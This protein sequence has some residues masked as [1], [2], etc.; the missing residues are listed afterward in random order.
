MNTRQ[1]TIGA[2]LVA[3]AL[4]AFAG[5]STATMSTTNTSGDGAA[6]RAVVERAYFNGAF[7]D[8]DTA[9]MAQGFHPDF[10]IFSAKGDALDRYEIETWISG[11]KKRRAQPDFDP[12]STAIEGRIVSLD[13]IGGAASAKIEL[14]REGTLI[15]TDYLSLLKFESGWKIAAKV[16]HKH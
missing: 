10:A 4:L 5:S 16:Y 1:I 3:V 15:Y 11:I 2:G 14:S 9:A 12:K 7:N 8:Q 13:V 6:V